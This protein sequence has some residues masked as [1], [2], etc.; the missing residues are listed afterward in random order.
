MNGGNKMERTYEKPTVKMISFQA[1]DA[2]MMS[3]DQGTGRPGGRSSVQSMNGSI[4]LY[5]D[6][7]I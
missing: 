3:T 4:V 2:L 6:D 1:E 5:P 7:G